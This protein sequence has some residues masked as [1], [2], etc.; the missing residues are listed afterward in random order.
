MGCYIVITEIHSIL[1]L[2]G[3]SDLTLCKRFHDATLLLADSLRS[4]YILFIESLKDEALK[5]KPR[6]QIC[7]CNGASRVP[8]H[9]C[10]GTTD[11]SCI[12]LPGGCLEESP[13][14]H[15]LDHCPQLIQEAN[16]TVAFFPLPWNLPVRSPLMESQGMQD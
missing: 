1:T 10:M 16:T 3:P 2:Q 15:G 8:E 13:D 5:N 6:N 7:Q 9:L 11:P 12:V 14:F 4:F